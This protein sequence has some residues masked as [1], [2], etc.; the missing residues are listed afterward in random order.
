MLAISFCI[1]LFVFY[2]CD[3]LSCK[4]SSSFMEF[5]VVMNINHNKSN[6]EKKHEVLKK[7]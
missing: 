6:N 4:A 7:K 3:T 5:A 1:I 2:F